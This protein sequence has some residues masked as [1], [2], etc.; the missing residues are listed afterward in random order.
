MGNAKR[1][2]EPDCPQ[3]APLRR[4]GARSALPSVD[5]LNGWEKTGLVLVLLVS[6]AFGAL[7]VLRSAYLKTRRTDADVYFRAAWAVRAGDNPYLV[8]DTNSWH[9]HYPPLMAILLAP[10]AVPPDAAGATRADGWVTYPVAVAVWYALGLA[11][12]VFALHLAAR[13]LERAWG[14][15]RLHDP[16]PS[17][18][19]WWRLRLF[20]LL[21]CVVPVGF[22][23]VRGQPNTL[24]LLGMAGFAAGWLSGRFAWAGLWLGLGACVKPY[25]GAVLLAALWKRRWR[26]AGG[27]LA[28][29]ALGLVVIPAVLVGPSRAVE[30]TRDFYELRLKGL[31]TG[32]MVPE[33]RL[34]L[35]VV[36][37]NFP[38]YG[39]SLFK[40]LHPDPAA[41]PP[42]MPDGYRWFGAALAA[43]LAVTT[44]W[45]WGWREPPGGPRP[46]RDLLAI[47]ALLAV[48]VPAMPTCKPHY[49]ALALPLVTGLIAW[50][51][52]RRGAPRTGPGL[53]LLLLCYAVVMAVEQ[54]P[55]LKFLREFGVLPLATLALWAAALKLLLETPP[56]PS[57]EPLPAI[58][59]QTS[60]N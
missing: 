52:E 44:L 34:E 14:V 19:P 24:L 31:L 39:V 2:A 32:E 13:G 12:L 26:A 45:A 37:G 36:P 15:P 54:L 22:S 60:E 6:L 1:T 47:G 17:G 49:Y 9:Y 5:R 56:Q 8:K 58:E 28:G 53:N 40:A 10:L 57:R 11:A 27:F 41:R 16:P 42:V 35:D 7:T 48:A 38:S 33:I 30:L 21:A 18:R 59:S 4:P 55:G 46:A 20:P 23:L 50:A 29:L 51:W 25:L 43:A 3:P